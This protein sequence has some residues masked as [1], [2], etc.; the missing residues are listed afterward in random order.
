[1][2]VNYKYWSSSLEGFGSI[3][4]VAAEK[5]E[6]FSFLTEGK[7]FKNMSDEYVESMSTA[8]DTVTFGCISDCDYS[9]D[10][11][12]EKDG[13]I[14]L[15]I[16][17]T[18]LNLNSQNIVFAKNVLA[19]ATVAHTF[20]I[21]WEAIQKRITSF[22]PTYGRSVIRKYDNVTVIDD[23]YNANYTSTLAA[24]ENLIQLPSD[25]RKIFVFGDMAEL[26]DY[27]KEYHKK[28][29]EKCIEF[30][31]DA[32]FLLGNETVKTNNYLD[33][34]QYHKHFIEKDNLVE[35][36]IKYIKKD[37]TILFKGSRSMEI[38]KIIQEVFKK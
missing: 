22:T 13:N 6:L 2:R 23:T 29:A 31:V 10:Y 30:D 15:I 38:E 17:T 28:I 16:N 37:D 11:Y 4:N 9:A 20:N 24:L 33:K 26:G 8:S 12:R 18:E 34:I 3:E 21:D 14:I 32:V 5:G 35:E 1:M 27:S 7:V 19:A 36:L 25:G